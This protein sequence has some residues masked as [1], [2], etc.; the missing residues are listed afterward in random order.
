[1]SASQP[2]GYRLVPLKGSRPWFLIWFSNNK[3]GA[4]ILSRIQKKQQVT[5]ARHSLCCWILSH[6]YTVRVIWQLFQLSKTSCT[7]PCIIQYFGHKRN[8]SSNYQ[9]SSGHLPLM[10][11]SKVPGRNRTHSEPIPYKYNIKAHHFESEEC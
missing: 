4:S 2:R 1:M 7:P 8:L 9:R 5:F 11:E 6:I 3:L 10:K